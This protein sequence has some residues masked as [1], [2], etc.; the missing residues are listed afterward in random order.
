MRLGQEPQKVIV[1]TQSEG[2]ASRLA[3]QRLRKLD[4]DEQFH[5]QQGDLLPAYHARSDGK[6]E[7][8]AIQNL[9]GQRKSRQNIFPNATIVV[10]TQAVLRQHPARLGEGSPSIDVYHRG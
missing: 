6:P 1:A 3:V 10:L 4:R 2:N 5:Y 7:Q 8:Q 9:F